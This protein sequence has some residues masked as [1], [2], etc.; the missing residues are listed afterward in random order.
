[1]ITT[2]VMIGIHLLEN[3]VVIW[4]LLWDYLAD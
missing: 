1:M 3:D 4:F 2:Y